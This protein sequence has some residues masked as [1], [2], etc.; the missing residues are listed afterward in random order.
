MCGTNLETAM[1]YQSREITDEPDPYSTTHLRHS[2]ELW[3]VYINPKRICHVQFHA[4]M[5]ERNALR[6]Q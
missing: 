2:T 5:I 1:E 3:M 4:V 6:F